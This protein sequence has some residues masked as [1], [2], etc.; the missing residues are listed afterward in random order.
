MV[1]A[2]GINVDPLME[3]ADVHMVPRW[4]YGEVKRD[5][6]MVNE[7][8]KMINRTGEDSISM[9]EDEGPLMELTDMYSVHGPRA[10]LWCCC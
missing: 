5:D 10:G 4:D 7:S 9:D 2:S 1:E 3:L 8:Q 6:T